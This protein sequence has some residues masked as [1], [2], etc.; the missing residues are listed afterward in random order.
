M[1]L[2]LDASTKYTD[3]FNI[4]TNVEELIQVV[5]TAWT[6]LIPAGAI[7]SLSYNGGCGSSLVSSSVN[8]VLALS[9]LYVW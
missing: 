5:T 8:V 2:I 4:D 1:E 9:C 3:M 7:L 6:D